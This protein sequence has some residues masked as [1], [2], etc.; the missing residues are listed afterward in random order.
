MS[1]DKSLQGRTA[2]VTGANTGIGRVT[3]RELARRGARVY[4]ATRDEART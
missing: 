1:K 2:L 4:V 3:A